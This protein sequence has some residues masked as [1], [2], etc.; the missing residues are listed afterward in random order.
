M[1][2]EIYEQDIPIVLIYMKEDELEAE[3][4]DSLSSW[5]DERWV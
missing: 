3:I 2:D 5:M 4:E 1:W